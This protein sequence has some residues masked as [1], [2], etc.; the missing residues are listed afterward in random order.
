MPSASI[1]SALPV[2]EVTARLPCLAT[3]TPAA[4][5]YG[6]GDLL[7]E[8][9]RASFSELAAPRVANEGVIQAT[10]GKS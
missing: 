1:T 2:F 4:P 7:G 5:A 9:R 6:I 3:A 8:V 10:L